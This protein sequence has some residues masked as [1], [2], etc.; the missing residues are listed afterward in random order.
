MSF[1]TDELEYKIRQLKRE[2]EELRD[3]LRSV[4]S[5]LDSAEFK[6]RTELE[7]RIQAERRAYDRHLGPEY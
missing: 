1:E 5:K 7:P 2:N 6:I 3:E 4:R